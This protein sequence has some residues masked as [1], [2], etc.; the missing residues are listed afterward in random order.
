MDSF[1]E[2]NF[3]WASNLIARALEAFPQPIDVRV[4]GFAN[5]TVAVKLR[6]AL[7]FKRLHPDYRL[8]GFP[9][10]RWAEV[11]HRLSVYRREDRV[12]IGPKNL[13]EKVEVASAPT[14]HLILHADQP[15]DLAEFLGLMVRGC[16]E[17]PCDVLVEAPWLTPQLRAEYE[18]KYNAVFA[19]AP[20]RAGYWE[21]YL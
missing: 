1:S 13:R 21:L 19:A 2:R 11:G 18:M 15:N 12:L 6:D 5:S 8:S 10:E 7:R 3:I 16:L 20:G 4:D 14:Q 17:L 9:E